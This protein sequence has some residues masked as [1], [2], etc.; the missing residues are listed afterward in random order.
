VYLSF[1]NSPLK[2]LFFY[3]FFTLGLGLGVE[4]FLVEDFSFWQSPPI[5]LDSFLLFLGVLTGVAVI[6]LFFDY[7]NALR[8]FC[9]IRVPRFLAISTVSLVTISFILLVAYL[10]VIGISFSTIRHGGSVSSLGAGPMF[11][12]QLLPLLRIVLLFELVAVWKYRQR[13]LIAPLGL[14]LLLSALLLSYSSMRSG[15]DILL[16]LLLFPGVR[17]RLSLKAVFLIVPALLVAGFI[18]KASDLSS[19]VNRLGEPGYIETVASV[20]TTSSLHSLRSSLAEV[21]SEDVGTNYINANLGVSLYRVALVLGQEGDKV[22]KTHSRLNY[23]RIAIDSEVHPRAGASPGFIAGILDL[24]LIFGVLATIWT[25]FAL[26]CISDTSGDSIL[27]LVVLYS[28]L[29]LFESPGNILI[30]TSPFYMYLFIA[31]IY[32]SQ[33]K[34]LKSSRGYSWIQNRP[35]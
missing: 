26:S 28:I 4:F 12:F 14:I 19:L 11:Y 33:R 8:F 18:Y 7:E 34:S 23:E 13:S 1:K 2:F 31:W 15:F 20:R 27:N 10:K 32:L 24:G 25:A 3:L 35:S 30:L 29:G 21:L 9:L 5:E 22:E 16:C 17:S 6:F